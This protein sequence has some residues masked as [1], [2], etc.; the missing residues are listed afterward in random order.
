MVHKAEYALRFEFDAISKGTI[1]YDFGLVSVRPETT[2]EK[3]IRSRGKWFSHSDDFSAS[4][5]IDTDFKDH[6]PVVIVFC[7]FDEAD[8]W[9][10]C[11][12]IRKP[13]FIPRTTVKKQIVW[14]HHSSDSFYADSGIEFNEMLKSFT[15]NFEKENDMVLFK[16]R[17]ALQ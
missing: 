12:G 13:R 16:L 11:V 2:E 4:C 10:D 5:D 14:K 1:A 3:S 15:L 6:N 9:F 7:W 8:T 17:W